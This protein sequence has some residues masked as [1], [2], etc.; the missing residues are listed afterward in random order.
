MKTFPTILCLALVCALASAPRVAAQ[1]PGAFSHSPPDSS[2]K[3][4]V[5]CHKHAEALFQKRQLRRAIAAE[6]EAI[7]L[8]P[9]YI[10]AYAYRALYRFFD[11]DLRGSIEDD[12]AA[13]KLDPQLP[14]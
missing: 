13:L 3:A 1:E 12:N 10:W 8:D 9:H 5:A 2:N 11:D 4:A 14:G 6:T 7:R